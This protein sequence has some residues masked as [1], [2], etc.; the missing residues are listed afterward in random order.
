M[1]VDLDGTTSGQFLAYGDATAVEGLTTKSVLFWLYQ[2]TYKASRFVSILS[3]SGAL[4]TSERED[5]VLNNVD[6]QLAYVRNYTTTNGLWSTSTN[7]FTTGALHH[8]AVTFS[9]PTVIFYANGAALTTTINIAPV[10]TLRT[11]SSDNFAVGGVGGG[12]F[13]IDGR[14]YSYLVYNRV[15]SAAEIAEA[16]ASKLAIP[17][18][19]GLVFAPQLWTRGEVGNG[20]T[21]TT[22]HTIADFVSGALG[23]PTASPLHAQDPYLTFDGI[24]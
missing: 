9:D 13:Q 19:R 3:N 20:G 1:A 8:G 7:P 18:T 21:L 23:V 24:S 2:D 6:G 14:I 10:G 4:T 5:V 17:I 15:L 11:G 12:A 22:S 16:Y